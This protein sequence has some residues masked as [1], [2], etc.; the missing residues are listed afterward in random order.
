MTTAAVSFEGV[1]K[2]YA[3]KTVLDGLSLQVP[4]GRVTALC[5]APGSGKSVLFRLLTGLEAPDAGR[6]VLNGE[7]VTR[8]SPGE[9]LVGYVPQSF[10]LYPHLSVYRNIAYPLTLRRAPREVVRTKVER[11]A[12]LLGLT[13]LLNKRP[14]EL[15]GGAGRPARRPRL[16]AA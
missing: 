13:D 1:Q 9:R 15:S 11:V 7:D 4:A 3:G 8:R 10:A 16:Q 12:A 5:G 2:R 14:S 6:I